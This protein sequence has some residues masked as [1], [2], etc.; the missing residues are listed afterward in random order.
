MNHW[1][2][3]ANLRPW[4]WQKLR[5]AGHPAVACRFPCQNVCILSTSWGVWGR[6]W[7]Y[8]VTVCGSMYS[9]TLPPRARYFYR[10]KTSTLLHQQ[11]MY[12]KTYREKETWSSN[13]L[14]R[15]HVRFLKKLNLLQRPFTA[16]CRPHGMLDRFSCGR[17]P[18]RSGRSKASVWR[19]GYHHLKGHSNQQRRNCASRMGIRLHAAKILTIFLKCILHW[20]RNPKGTM[21][22]SCHSTA[23]S[24]IFDCLSLDSSA[25]SWSTSEYERRQQRR[26]GAVLEKTRKCLGRKSATIQLLRGIAK[27]LFFNKFIGVY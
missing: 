1:S 21:T 10:R 17:W 14:G 24:C 27:N 26:F 9:H 5:L 20:I 12:N 23:R 18:L 8:I 7:R 16:C 15:G 4:D 13:H 11:Q 6:W 22:A 3:T 25:G 19:H 2:L